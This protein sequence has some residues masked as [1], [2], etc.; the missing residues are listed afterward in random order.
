MGGE[1]RGSAWYTFSDSEAHCESNTVAE[2]RLR[3]TLPITRAMRGFGTH[4]LQ[5]DAWLVARYDFSKGPGTQYFERNLMTSLDHRGASGPR[6]M[7]TNSTLQY[8][9]TEPI[10]VPAGTFD[11]HHFAFVA[12]SHGYP[13]FHLWVSA[14]GHFH[15]VHAKL[16]GERAKRFDLVQLTKVEVPDGDWTKSLTR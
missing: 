6:F 8:F 14:D 9:G 16:G 15:F 5:A 4:S 12:T 13:S 11:C 7:L 3:Q 2:G 1:F 10:E